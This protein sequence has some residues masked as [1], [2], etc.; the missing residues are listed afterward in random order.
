MLTLALHTAMAGCDVAIQRDGTVLASLSEAMR[1]GQDARLPGLVAEA[2]EQAGVTLEEI[3]RLGVVTGPGSF[4]GV[5]V[6]VAFARG[7]ALATGV[8]CVGISSLEAALPDGQQGSA[9]VLLPAQ[10]RPPEITYWAQTFRSGAA[11][12]P[13][14]EMPLDAVVELLNAHPHMVF[15]DAAA[16]QDALPSLSIRP[17]APSALRAAALTAVFDPERHPPRPSYARAPDAALPGGK[18]LT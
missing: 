13:P 10:K 12:A 11:T 18:T 16:L 15:G 4:T 7:L 3:E 17:A 8:P 9:I 14:E 5:R 6:G 1:K 2:C